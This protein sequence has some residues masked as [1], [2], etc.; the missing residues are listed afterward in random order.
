[1]LSKETVLETLSQVKDPELF[2]DIVSLG[3]IYEVKIEN[4]VV[5]VLMTLTFPGCPYGPQLI[6]ETE[7]A[8]GKI[9]GVKDSHLQITFDPPWSLEKISEEAR[10]TL[11]I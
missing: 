7:K 6:K 11:G 1:M 5:S 2:L 8:L 9:P 4:G 3:L 10:L